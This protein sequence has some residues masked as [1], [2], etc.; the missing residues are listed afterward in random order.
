MLIPMILRPV[1]NSLFIAVVANMVVLIVA[2]N[3]YW[4]TRPGVPYKTIVCS[5]VDVHDAGF[6]V[7]LALVATFFFGLPLA[8]W[9][10]VESLKQRAR[11]SI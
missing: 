2:R 7:L 3:F 4:D 10:G 11:H 8:I 6:L 9:G 5:N 1:K